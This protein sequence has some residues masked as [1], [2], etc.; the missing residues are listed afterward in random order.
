MSTEQVFIPAWAV[1]EFGEK[2]K[3]TPS[4]AVLAEEMKLLREFYQAWLSYHTIPNDGRQKDRQRRAGA[5]LIVIHEGLQ[6]WM[7]HADAN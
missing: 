6:K 4:I 7:E 2:I 5:A 1:D 3:A